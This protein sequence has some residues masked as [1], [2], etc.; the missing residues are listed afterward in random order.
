MTLAKAGSVLET[1]S[2]PG[3]GTI[4]L[5]GAV[6]DYSTYA[7]ALTNGATA[8]SIITAVNSDGDPT[9]DYEVTQGVYSSSTLTRATTFGSSAGAGTKVNFAGSV[10]VELLSP[11]E[12][13][14]PDE[15]VTVRQVIGGNQTMVIRANHCLVVPGSFEVRGDAVLTVSGTL[16][17]T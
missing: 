8:I 16:E 13:L 7:S 5:T 14:T 9:G 4:T 2:A 3:T 10:R 17:V 1:A 12:P 11:T 6:A 15:P